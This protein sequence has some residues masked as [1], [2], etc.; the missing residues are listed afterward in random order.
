MTESEREKRE[1]GSLKLPNLNPDSIDLFGDAHVV[2]N[3]DA[4]P[5]VRLTIPSLFSSGLLRVPEPLLFVDAT[6]TLSTEFSF[7]I[8]GNGDGILFVLTVASTNGSDTLAV[9]NASYVG[10]V[11]INGEKLNAWVDYEGGPKVMEVRLSKWGEQMPSDPIVSHKIDQ[12]SVME[13]TF[14]L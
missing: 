12:M 11:L 8:F 9:A 7:S 1:R 10:L 14:I 4:A 3:N 5:H 6:T 2:T 13:L